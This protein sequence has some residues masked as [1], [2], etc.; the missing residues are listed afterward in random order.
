MDEKRERAEERRIVGLRSRHNAESRNHQRNIPHS[1]A[2]HLEIGA[3]FQ[4]PRI[5]LDKK[6]RILQA[7]HGKSI[8]PTNK[9]YSPELAKEFNNP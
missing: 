7:V 6:D 9:N 4:R 1:R 2:Y 8:I 3:E 5:P